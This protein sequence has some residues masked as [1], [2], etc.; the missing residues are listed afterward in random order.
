MTTVD[1][2]IA[3]AG[4]ALLA[5]VLGLGLWASASSADKFP[6]DWDRPGWEPSGRTGWLVTKF[7]WLSGGR[8]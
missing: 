2:G 5:T 8:G 6:K 7:T 1:V 3:V 4:L